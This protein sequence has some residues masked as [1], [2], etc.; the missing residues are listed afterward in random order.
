MHATG[1]Y[2]FVEFAQILSLPKC[3]SK[4]FWKVWR[5]SPGC[6]LLMWAVQAQNQN[7]WSSSLEEVDSSQISSCQNNYLV[8]LAS[9]FSII[10]PAC[11]SETLL[12]RG[13]AH[14]WITTTSLKMLR[15]PVVLLEHMVD[16]QPFKMQLT[17]VCIL[18]VERGWRNTGTTRWPWPVSW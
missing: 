5:K 6:L 18:L 17:L 15:P 8:P 1:L 14:H 13:L 2:M 10:L 12:S 3:L 11:M 16:T 7:K 4:T 9:T